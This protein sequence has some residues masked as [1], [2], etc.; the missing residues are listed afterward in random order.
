MIVLTFRPA[1]A[2]ESFQYIEIGD[3]RSD[4]SVEPTELAVADAPSRASQHVRGGDVLTSMVR[5]IR[6]LS[7]AVSAEHDG[8]VCSSGFVVLRPTSISTSSLL[9]YLRLP[10]IC[11]LMD[12]HTSASLYPAIS[13]RDLLALP[14]P[15]V[16]TTVQQAV[17]D[18]VDAAWSTKKHAKRLLEAAIRAV[19]IAIE[20]SEGAAV[21]YLEVFE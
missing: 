10:L 7:A 11:E 12:L 9:T 16:S 5:P 20:D 14:I 17:D 2:E 18:K 1:K 8:A 4:G 13:E 6:R 21:K 15:S 3:L 19:S